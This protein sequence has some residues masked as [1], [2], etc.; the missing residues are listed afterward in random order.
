MLRQIIPPKTVLI[1]N[2][3]AAQI[4]RKT[5]FPGGTKRTGHGASHLRGNTYGPLITRV[6]HEHRFHARTIYQRQNRFIGIFFLAGKNLRLRIRKPRNPYR[7]LSAHFPRQCQQVR[8]GFFRHSKKLPLDLSPTVR[9]RLRKKFDKHIMKCCQGHKAELSE[10]I[11]KIT[12]WI[13]SFQTITFLSYASAHSQARSQARLRASTVSWLST[14]NPNFS[15]NDIT[16]N[17]LSYKYI[18]GEKS[19]SSGGTRRISRKCSRSSFFKTL[20]S[21]V[22]G[23]ITRALIPRL[24]RRSK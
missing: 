15:L 8:P 16:E 20:P 10:T 7:E 21:G 6:G 5:H 11:S 1:N 12:L 23:A 19:N 3:I 13:Q 2:F 4:T 9:R 24:A 18:S 22:S 14:I 17:L